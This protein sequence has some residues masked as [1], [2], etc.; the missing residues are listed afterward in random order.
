VGLVVSGARRDLVRS[1]LLREADLDAGAGAEAAAALAAHAREELPGARLELSYDVRYRGQAFELTVPA[2]VDATTAVLRERF[3]A[4]HAERYG[5]SGEQEEIELVNV[6]VAA[7][8]DRRAEAL[9]AG[10][11]AGS[12]ERGRRRARF[13]AGVLDTAVVRGEP[14]PGDRFDGPAV[15]ELPETTV[16][17]P[18]GWQAARDA[19]GALTM[20]RE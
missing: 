19:S 15:L 4:A 16:V 17:V 20:E 2:P 6:R 1:V 18:P 8:A 3:E 12:L 11:A 10:A 5:Y 13:S 9:E 7:V 14:Q